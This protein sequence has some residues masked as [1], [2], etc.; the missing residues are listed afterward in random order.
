MER[1][2]HNYANL[3]LKRNRFLQIGMMAALAT[4]LVA[5]EWT[6]FEEVETSLDL[7]LDVTAFE[8]EEIPIYMPRPPERPQPE[9]VTNNNLPP[10]IGNPDPPVVTPVAPPIDTSFVVFTDDTSLWTDEPIPVDEPMEPFLIVE[11]MPCW[12]TDQIIPKDERKAFTDGKIMAYLRDNVVYPRMAV[13]GGITGVVYVEYVVNKHGEVTETKVV[14]GVHSVLDK[15]A[16]RV[17]RNMP[18]FTPG[19]QRGKNVPVR[20]T[21]PIRFT[22][23]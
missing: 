19:K 11:D 18:N 5:F 6:T 12:V 4:V 21:L 16:L 2:K 8:A 7:G 14:R 15:E 17:V 22:L 20:F 10:V 23:N 3:E 9:R 13:D 1:K